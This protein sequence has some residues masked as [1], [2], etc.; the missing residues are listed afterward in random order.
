MRDD[1]RSVDAM[2]L[3]QRLGE[4]LPRDIRVVHLDSCDSTNRECQRRLQATESGDELWVISADHQQAGRGRRGKSWL[5]RSPE[6][7]Y[8]SVGLIKDLP[9]EYLGL[10]PLLVGVSLAES[11]LTLGFPVRLKWPNDLLLGDRKLAGI[12]LENRPL[13][14]ERHALTIGFGINRCL[15]IHEQE[16]IGQPATSL[17]QHG[18][19]PSR[20]RLLLSLLEGLLPELIGFGPGQVEQLS[21]RFSDLDAFAD[22]QAEIQEG[23]D[24]LRGICRGIDNRGC[25]QVEVDGSLRSFHAAEIS[26]RPIPG[27]DHATT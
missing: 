2:E 19:P 1:G 10:L 22:R 14:Q 3:E 20:Q 6:N 26:L 8:C 17:Q 16:A 27:G 21:Q 11:L 12:L 7:L 9:A 4:G 24:R 5:S 18:L 15:D 13:N 25:L 23:A